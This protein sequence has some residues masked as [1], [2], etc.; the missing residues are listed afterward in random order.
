MEAT[1]KIWQW[2]LR[3]HNHPA[4]VSLYKYLGLININFLKNFK[5]GLTK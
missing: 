5:T 3:H 4:C 2:C 1:Y